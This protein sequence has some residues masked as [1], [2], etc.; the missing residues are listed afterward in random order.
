MAEII[1]RIKFT[2]VKC[3]QC[4]LMYF[5]PES[6]EEAWRKSGNGFW[7]P[8]GHS[9]TF[10]DSENKKLKRELDASKQREETIRRQRDD[11]QRLKD[12]A[13]A[14]NT[15]LERKARLAKKRAALGVCPCCHRT[16]SQM[17]RHIK[18]KHP[19]FMPKAEPAKVEPK[20]KEKSAYVKGRLDAILG[21]A[22][23]S[24][25]GK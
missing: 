10:G 3:C 7:C 22:R 8:N 12:A 21:S 14:A 20:V 6:V 9:L 19:D 25:V 23:T 16:V 15:D 24:E 17:A 2:E 4:G 5:V 13:L 1:E 18:S 11:A